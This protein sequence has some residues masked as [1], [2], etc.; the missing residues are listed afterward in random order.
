MSDPTLRLRKVLGSYD[1][2]AVAV[3]GGVD[4]LTLAFCAAKWVP[5][6]LAIHAVSP[7]VPEEAT[8]RV[9][10]YAKENAWTLQVVSSGEFSDPQY[11]ANPHNRCYFCK[12]NLY[13]TMTKLFDGPV[14]SG[15]NTD[16]LGDYRPGLVAADEHRVV[17]PFVE[18]NVSKSDLREIARGFGLQDIADLPAQ[19]CLSSRVETGI[20]IT[21][22]DLR[23]IHRMETALRPFV[24]AANLRCRISVQGVRIESDLELPAEARELAEDLCAAESR[25]LAGLTGYARGSAFIVP[26][27]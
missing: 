27:K 19:P 15:T 26:G 10:S 11:R 5:D 4:S 24:P 20:R 1:R 6:F 8:E 18:A 17:H 23:F 9:R 12:T 16:D 25:T 13:G 3:S 21:G 14:A 7:A 2:L 22:E